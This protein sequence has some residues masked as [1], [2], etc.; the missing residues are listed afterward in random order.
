MKVDK[1][2]KANNNIKMGQLCS[3]DTC[4]SNAKGAPPALTNTGGTPLLDYIAY[5]SKEAAVS[6]AALEVAL[7]DATRP[8][9]GAG[10]FAAG[11]L[12]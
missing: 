10:C 11:E 5:L 12:A 3:T 8:R 1:K 4:A 9:D 7:D 2:L 6:D